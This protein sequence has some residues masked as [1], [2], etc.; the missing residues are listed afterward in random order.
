VLVGA[1]APIAYYARLLVIGIARPDHVLEPVNAWRPR[2]PPADPLGVRRRLATAWDVNR[3]FTTAVIAA[4]LAVLS[5][6]TAAGAFDGPVAAAGPP[7][8]VIQPEL[9]PLPS[10]DVPAPSG[11]L[12]G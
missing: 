8:V 3:P 9:G 5:L 10:L 2:I 12:P 1:L 6:A 11:L 7:P 4:A